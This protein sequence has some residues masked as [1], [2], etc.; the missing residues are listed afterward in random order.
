MVEVYLWTSQ[1]HLMQLTIRYLYKLD[2]Y[3]IDMAMVMLYLNPTLQIEGSSL[4][5]VVLNLNRK[6]WV[7]ETQK[8]LCLVGSP[9]T[10]PWK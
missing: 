2:R 5:L 1:M 7:A 10:K 8:A 4:L 6:A 3:A 9:A